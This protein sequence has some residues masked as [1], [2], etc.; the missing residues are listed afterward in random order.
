[1]YT[2]LAYR[3]N[4]LHRQIK[5][6]TNIIESTGDSLMPYIRQ[7]ITADFDNNFRTLFFTNN[8]MFPAFDEGYVQ[9]L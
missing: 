9:I 4:T 8:F 7:N 2:A 6:V 5:D 3:L 1:M